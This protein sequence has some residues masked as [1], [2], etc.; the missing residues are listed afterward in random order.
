[1][2]WTCFRQALAVCLTNPKAIG[3]FVAFFP[4]FLTADSQPYTLVVMMAHVS[5]IS[6][7]YQTGLVLVGNAV[8][9]R[10]SRFQL[11]HV[12]GRRLVGLGLVGFSLKLAANRR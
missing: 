11:A 10:L 1:V 7:V 2:A 9:V 5:L 6:L 8:A 12:L 3:F 4:Q